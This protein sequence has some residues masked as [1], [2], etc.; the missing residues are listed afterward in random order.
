MNATLLSPTA[1]ECKKKFLFYFPKGFYD[2]KYIAWERGYKWDAHVEWEKTLNESTYSALLKKKLY[3]EVALH[4]VKIE[5]KTNL[6]F[7]F[8]KMALRDGIKT[9]ESS[10]V[11]AESL[12]QYVYG[13]STIRDRFENFA[14]VLDP[15][16]ETYENM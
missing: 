6:L 14:E 8:E 13:K 1:I 5:T 2:P 11:F 9:P 15:N 16:C 3:A 7:S 12:Y 10:R 4:A